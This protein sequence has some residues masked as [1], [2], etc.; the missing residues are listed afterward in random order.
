MSCAIN[1]TGAPGT[2]RRLLT[3]EHEDI[4]LE[5]DGGERVPA[6][7]GRSRWRSRRSPVPPTWASP[8]AAVAVCSA[9]PRWPGT[10]DVVSRLLRSGQAVADSTNSSGRAWSSVEETALTRPLGDPERFESLIATAERAGP[11]G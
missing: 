9:R 6:S 1:P 10:G 8:R 4:A 7:A 2:A 3:G 5:L 11:R